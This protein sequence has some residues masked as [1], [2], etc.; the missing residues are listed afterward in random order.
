MHATP[1]LRLDAPLITHRTHALIRAPRYIHKCECTLST[2]QL[3][4]V[5]RGLTTLTASDHTGLHVETLKSQIGRR[6]QLLLGTTC[7]SQPWSFQLS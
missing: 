5:R 1:A 2:Q 4:H 3:L 6:R 7:L